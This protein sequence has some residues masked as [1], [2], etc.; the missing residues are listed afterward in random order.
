MSEIEDPHVFEEFVECRR[1]FKKR[2][3]MPTSS[4][5]GMPEFG[6]VKDQKPNVQ[7]WRGELFSLSHAN[8]STAAVRSGVV[9][10][11]RWRYNVRN[12]TDVAIVG[13]GPYGLS[14]AAHLRARE[15]GFRI[16]GRAMGTWRSHMPAGMYL[17]SEGFATN[18]YDSD[19]S[20]TLARFCAE[21]GIAYGDVGVPVALETFCTYG[22]TF[23]RRFVP[24]LEQRDIIALRRNGGGFELETADGE[25]VRA[26]YVVLAIGISHFHHLP[27]ELDGLPS[28]FVSHSSQHHELEGFRG[29]N[30]IVVGAGASAADVAALLG[31]AGASVRLVART[32]KLEFQD[33]PRPQAPKLLERLR[34]PRSGLGRGWK[35]RFYSDAPGLFYRLPERFR[36]TIVRTHAGPAPCWFTKEDVVGKVET[37]LGISLERAEVHGERVHLKMGLSEGRDITLT[38][39]HIVAGTGYRVDVQ[40]LTF[41]SKELRTSIRSAAGAPVLSRDFESS[42]PGLFFVGLAA[43]NT[44]GPMLRFAFGAK[45]AAR[46]LSK[47]LT[48]R[49][50]RTAPRAPASR[51]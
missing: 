46:R 27:R 19:S 13:A 38:A 47:H 41:L 49:Q 23:Q 51:L 17:K 7:L 35:S 45:Y 3:V 15:V 48:A 36:H 30:V 34:R 24:S 22:E 26:R 43:A 6:D 42:V 25:R 50:R 11:G 32:T 31:R 20:F 12:V 29:R 44:F 8:L 1:A 37:V 4:S 39:D 5:R 14:I 2:D 9:G 28:A 10:L 21:Q 18:L 33:P 40:R 16:F